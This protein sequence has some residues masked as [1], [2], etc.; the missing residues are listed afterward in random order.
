MQRASPPGP[1]TVAALR[2]AT[3]K[4]VDAWWSV[5][6]AD[7]V[8]LRVIWVLLRVR[9]SLS[10]HAVTA[11]SLVV[12]LVAGALFATGHWV[13]GA[14]TYQLSFL[15]DCIDGKV[16]RWHGMASPRGGFFDGMTNTIVYVAALG[17]MI[18]RVVGVGDLAAAWGLVALVALRAI[19]LQASLQQANVQG[20]IKWEEGFAASADS[21][22]TRHRMLP[23][24]SFPDKHF[25]LFL[26]GPLTGMV[27]LRVVVA[28][29]ILLEVALAARKSRRLL[30]ALD[31]AA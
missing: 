8:A 14:V 25:L 24:F 4:R 18:V 3:Y 30:R 20:R 5:F 27:G 11:A 12:G 2:Q 1:P 19:N 22:L 15:G 26:V 21:W 29:N 6:V 23:P 17:G 13:A 31:E 10:P 28:V 16:A 9:P 7:P